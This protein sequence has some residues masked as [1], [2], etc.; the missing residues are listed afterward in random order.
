[1]KPRILRGGEAVYL[2]E[3]RKILGYLFKWHVGEE[4]DELCVALDGRVNVCRDFRFSHKEE[5]HEN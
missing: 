5:R 2:M 4:L 1:M 3:E